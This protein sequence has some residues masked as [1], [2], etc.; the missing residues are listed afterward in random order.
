[1]IETQ[2]AQL[3]A[4]VPTVEFGRFWGNLNLPLKM[5]AW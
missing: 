3:A 5:L 4:S 1:M 2:L